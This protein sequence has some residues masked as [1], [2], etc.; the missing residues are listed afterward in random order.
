MMKQ[1]KKQLCN[2]KIYNLQF[3]IFP[4]FITPKINTKIRGF[5]WGNIVPINFNEIFL[6]F[7]FFSL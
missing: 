2:D 6:T 5:L 3:C 4:K 7:D 1:I